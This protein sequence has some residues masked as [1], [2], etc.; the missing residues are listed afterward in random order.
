MD[1][2][3][4]LAGRISG[5]G[6]LALCLVAGI[7]RLSGNFWIGGFQVGTLLQAGI[8]ALVAGCFLLLWALT[9]RAG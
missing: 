6:G 8:G 7:A 3:L 9:E 4:S 2:L 5:V 1:R